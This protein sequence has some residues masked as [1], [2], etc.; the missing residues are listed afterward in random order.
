MET[1]RTRPSF[2][3]DAEAARD[4]ERVAVMVRG[5]TKTD[6]PVR[7]GATDN[8]VVDYDDTHKCIL[9]YG[10]EIPAECKFKLALNES[11]TAAVINLLKQ[12]RTL[13]VNEFKV[14]S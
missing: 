9:V 5:I 4:R 14:G 2:L 10:K 3:S 12:A 11:E 13:F 6:C 7:I 1:R 8:F